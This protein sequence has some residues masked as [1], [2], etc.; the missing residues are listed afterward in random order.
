MGVTIGW[1]FDVY[2]FV[3]VRDC[4]LVNFVDL[5]VMEEMGVYT[6]SLLRVDGDVVVG[7][8]ET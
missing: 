6:L 5:G 3:T 1:A 8:A 7:P 2:V 4:F